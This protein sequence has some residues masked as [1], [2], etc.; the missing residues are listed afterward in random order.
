LI[1]MF[2]FPMCVLTM[3][4]V[5]VPGLQV[6]VLMYEEYI[7]FIPIYL[8]GNVVIGFAVMYLFAS[9]LYR[10]AQTMKNFL[11]RQEDAYALKATLIQNLVLAT[12]AIVLTTISGFIVVFYNR[13]FS[14]HVVAYTAIV[15]PVYDMLILGT[16]CRLM[17]TNF[18]EIAHYC[19][20]TWRPKHNGK[21]RRDVLRNVSNVRAQGECT[22]NAATLTNSGDPSA[23][24]EG[25]GS[26]NASCGNL[27][28][29]SS[30]HL[31]DQLATASN[32]RSTNSSFEMTPM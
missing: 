6:C 17:L 25:C 16:S 13:S 7:W 19:Q 29:F 18:Q 5:I 31:E 11:G 28:V 26:E 22:S 20:T 15:F 21:S 27:H 10:Y 2:S 32:V 3:R 4:G 23:N 8:C 1:P 30:Q 9:P 14:S 24:I 12:S